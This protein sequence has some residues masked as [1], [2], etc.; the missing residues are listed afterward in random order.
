MNVNMPINLPR[1]SNQSQALGSQTKY[2]SYIAN[3]N[4]N[5]IALGNTIQTDYNCSNEIHYAV[6]LD[7][8][9]S[10]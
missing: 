7:K 3:N 5:Y 2:Q 6:I 10:I 4:Y 9:T 8:T 1:I